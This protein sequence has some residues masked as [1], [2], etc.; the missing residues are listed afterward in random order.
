VSGRTRV[1]SF[2][3]LHPGREGKH[4]RTEC[5]SIRA[6]DTCELFLTPTRPQETH[7]FHFTPCS[8][9]G[10]GHAAATASAHL[11]LT[12]GQ[13]VQY[14][15]HPELGADLLA[16]GHVP[17]AGGR[18]T[19][20]M[21]NDEQHGWEVWNGRVHARIR[22]ELRANA[23]TRL[24]PADVADLVAVVAQLTAHF[25]R[26]SSAGRSMA[27]PEGEAGVDLTNITEG[28]LAARL[29]AMRQAG[30]EFPYTCGACTFV[31]TSYPTQC[32]M[33]QTLNP[34]Y[35]AVAIRLQGG[36]GTREPHLGG[37]AVPTDNLLVDPTSSPSAANPTSAPRRVIMVGDLHGNLVE[38]LALWRA[39]EARFGEIAVNRATVVFL[40]DYCDRGPN[41]RGVL[42]WLI[43]LRDSRPPGST[44]FLAGNHDF[45]FAAF[46]GCL[47]VDGVPDPTFLE[48][49]RNPKWTSGLFMHAVDGG[50]HYQ[51][52][53][54]GGSAIYNAQETFESYGVPWDPAATV[55]ARDAL[56]RAVPDA[57]RE[58]L[59]ALSWVHDQ[60][61]DYA[62]H[63]LICVHAG[64]R[65][66]VSA[67]AQLAALKAKD[68]AA[69][70]LNERGDVARF[71]AF[72]G[73]AAVLPSPPDL[74]D[75]YVV[76]GHHG[77]HKIAGNR[78]I[79]DAS[80][81]EPSM[82]DPIQAFILPDRTVVDSS[83]GAH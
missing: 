75:A 15:Q 20:W 5:D 3:E 10:R 80:G 19:G 6:V 38:T 59:R 8:R 68:L 36:E 73:R 16:T 40:G 72:M 31:N 65:G 17:I 9:R 55:A 51:G 48:S 64:L 76:S 18:S 22:A 28:S 49:T 82:R 62:P 11:Q 60:N 70:V 67:E 54:W 29:D 32:E 56:L 74:G 44:I 14:E 30:L 37:S 83:G 21:H 45:S 50:M 42:D 53:R 1:H 43:R 57:H 13:P 12:V 33:C 4:T 2:G 35:A 27:C 47:P 71:A 79:I 69:D 81:G 63:R 23:A 77:F 66:D 25:D 39:V 34:Q 41:T 61:L 7:T 46:L 78:V 26:Y 24:E 52:R 58:F